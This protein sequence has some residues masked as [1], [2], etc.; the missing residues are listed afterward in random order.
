M[1]KK[2]WSNHRRVLLR[3]LLYNYLAGSKIPTAIEFTESNQASEETAM[4]VTRNAL[5]AAQPMWMLGNSAY[6]MLDWHDLLLTAGVDPVTPYN[7]R[8]TDNSPEIEYWS[9][10]ALRTTVTRSSSSNQS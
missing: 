8:N 1:C 9:K 6:D 2:L 10:L 7:P 3:L 4:L 5:A